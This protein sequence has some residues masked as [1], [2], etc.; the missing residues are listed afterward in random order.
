MTF[1]N[2]VCW[3]PEQVQRIMNI[4]ATQSPDHVFLAT[5]HPIAIKRKELIKGESEIRYSEEEFLRDFLATEDFAFVPVLGETGTGKSHLIRWLAAHIK[6]TDT[7]KVLLIPKIGTNLKD[8]IGLIFNIEGI[9]GKIFDDYRKRLNR[10]TS[11]L[12]ELQAREQLLNQLAIA[13][14]LN[15]RHDRSQL[16]EVQDHL[17]EELDS[18]LYD[19]FFREHWLKNGEIIHHLVTHIIGRR[20]TVEIVEE[21]REFS[22]ADLPLNVLYLQK[23]GEKARNF[24]STLISDDYIQKE[25]VDWLNHNLDEAIRQVLSLGREDLQRLM[26]QV[27]ETLA[28]KGIELV[29][30]IEDFAKLQGID[31]E[32]LEAVLARPQQPGSKPLCAIRTALACTTGYFESLIDTVQQRVTFSVNLDVGIVG[33]QS[34]VTEADK[35]SRLQVA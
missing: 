22:I 26:R 21:R 23:A 6:S 20:D 34:L 18:L 25:T 9:E 7:R 27:R 33:A 13:V 35:L 32:V 29:L 10:A 28:E 31:R 16:T 15:G 11:T 2:F 4:E 12:T 8:I 5:H 17:V 19:P 24:Y 3:H 1:Q 14:G 30:L